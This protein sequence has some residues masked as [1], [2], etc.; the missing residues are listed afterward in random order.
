M[1]LG[2]NYPNL[3]DYLQ[4]EK[5]PQ[6]QQPAFL[7]HLYGKIAQHMGDGGRILLITLTKKSAEEVTNFLISQ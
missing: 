1:S 4:L 2:S 7:E 6:G 5:L 3:P